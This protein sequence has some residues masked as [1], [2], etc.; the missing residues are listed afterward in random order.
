MMNEY[1]LII[2]QGTTGTRSTIVNKEGELIAY[3]YKE[4]KQIY[5]KPG[6]VEHD[7]TEIWENTKQVI[8]ESIKKAKIETRQIRGIGVTNQRETTIIWNPKT[9]K[10]YYNAIVWQDTRTKNRCQQLREQ[11]YEELINKKTGLYSFTYF[12]STKIEWILN[13]ISNLREKAKKGKAIFG[14][15]DTWIIWNLTRNGET[16]TPSK[17]GAHVTDYTNASRTMLMNIEKL[18]WDEELLELFKIPIE[19]MPEIRPS[20]DKEYYGYTN[21]NSFLHAEVPVAGD[22]GDQQAALVGQAAFEEGMA[23]NTYGTGCFLLLNIGANP[24][25][26]KHGLL[27]TVAYGF[28]KNKVTYALEGSV[29]IAGAVIQWLRDN[30]KIISSAKETEEIARSVSETGSGGIYF[31]PAFSGLFAPYWD[32]DARGIIIGLTRFIRKEHIVHAALESIAWQTRDVFEAMNKDTGIKL[33]KLRVD[34]GAV[35]NNYLMQLQ[36]NILGVSV[37]RPKIIETTSLGVAYATGLAT[38]YWASIKEISELWRLDRIFNPGW[39]DEKREKLYKGWKE[40][41]NRTRNWLKI[42]GE[43]PSSGVESV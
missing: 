1:I 3:S 24:R 38:D 15:I 17:H 40:A 14:T 20:S 42:V 21:K 7:P 25:Y 11:G 39:D 12:S 28:E 30:L 41:V 18:A 32:L 29:A 33:K 2:D 19:I 23:K 26:S 22:L 37:E 36:A 9:G 10:P 13:K 6:W 4:H 8:L 43:L 16:I 35:V 27:T 31:V 34:G 5:P